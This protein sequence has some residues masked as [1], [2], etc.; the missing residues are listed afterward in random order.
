MTARRDETSRE[1]TD[2]DAVA[3]PPPMVGNRTNRGTA[4]RHRT[5]DEPFE[6]RIEFM[7]LDAAAGD[8]LR[9]RQARIVR[10]VLRWLAEHPDHAEQ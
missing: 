2:A 6:V 3:M 10:K 4:S 9:I 5:S 7:Q 8:A 1:A